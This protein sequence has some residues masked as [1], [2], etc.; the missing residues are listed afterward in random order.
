MRDPEDPRRKV[1]VFA[2]GQGGI[3]RLSPVRLPPCETVFCLSVHKSQ[4][5]EFDEVVL[6]L[7]PRPSPL[8][9]RELIYTGITRAVHRVILVGT[10]EVLVRALGQRVQ[11]A[12]GLEDLL[13]GSEDRDAPGVRRDPGP[14]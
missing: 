13:W 12:S 11:R 1:V 8:M 14:R 9:T 6:V 7:A 5:S 3:R 10:R 4:G 2:D